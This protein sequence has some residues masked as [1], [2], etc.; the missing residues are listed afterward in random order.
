MNYIVYMLSQNNKTY[1]IC[2][3]CANMHGK[4]SETFNALCLQCIAGKQDMVI[5]IVAYDC[6]RM[7]VGIYCS[8]TWMSLTLFLSFYQ[9][10]IAIVCGS[11]PCISSSLLY[12]LITIHSDVLHSWSITTS[13]T[14]F[15]TLWWE[16]WNS[17]RVIIDL[18]YN[19]MALLY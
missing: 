11:F 16:S 18:I 8:I 13:Q 5:R 2:K 15:K 12:I 17:I 3:H 10:T 4:L 19:Y 14:I 9:C 1:Y 6:V 7:V